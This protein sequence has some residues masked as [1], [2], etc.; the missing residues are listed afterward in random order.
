MARIRTLGTLVARCKQR[1]GKANDAYPADADWKAAISEAYGDLYS[2]VAESGLRHFESESTIT[3]TGA[4]SYNAPTDHLGTVMVYRVV[5]AAG[6][7]EPLD[8]LMVQER[9]LVAGSTSAEARFFEH[10]GALIYLYPNPSSGTYKV[11]YIPQPADLSSGI[12]ALDVD[13]INP[14]GEEFLVWCVAVKMHSQ[15]E[16]DAQLALDREARAR[17]NLAE[18]ASLKAFNQPRRRVADM[19]LVPD[20]GYD[21][22][23]W[24]WR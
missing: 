21:P 2:V 3:A 23:D 10:V 8:E 1:L 4:A 9:H 24:R 18:W 16:S 20:Y 13:V 6:E 12:D 19:R 14:Y 17:T 7:L 11:R 22:A 15:L 5:N